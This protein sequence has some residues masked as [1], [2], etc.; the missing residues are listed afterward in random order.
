[1]GLF[2]KGSEEK[3]R[4]CLSYN[5]RSTE[6]LCKKICIEANRKIKI[7]IYQEETKK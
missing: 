4:K 2:F 6:K 5:Q 7:S 1:M 3:I